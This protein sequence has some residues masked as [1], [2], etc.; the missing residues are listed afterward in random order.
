MTNHPKD[1]HVLAAA[2]RT[3]AQTIVT[4]DLKDFPEAALP[5]SN[6]FHSHSCAVSANRGKTGVVLKNHTRLTEPATS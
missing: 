2:L 6:C 1:R 4:F 5:S 3:G